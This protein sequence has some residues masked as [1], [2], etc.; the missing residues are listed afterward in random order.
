[1]RP[2]RHMY[3]I[4]IYMWRNIL[5]MNQLQVEV[6]NNNVKTLETAKVIAETKGVKRHPNNIWC[7]TSQRN[8]KKFYRV[9][10]DS[11]LDIFV[12]DCPYFE[13]KGELCKHILASCYA[14]GEGVA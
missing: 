14:E 6:K 4:R 8:P 5:R 7:V 10:F 2:L 1:M 9:M 13:K 3:A 11:D 12:C